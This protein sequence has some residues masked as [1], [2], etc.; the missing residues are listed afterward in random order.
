MALT[1]TEKHGVVKLLGLPGSVLTTTSPSYSSIVA[2]R[3]TNLDTD[4]E[5]SVRDYLT[6]IATLDLALDAARSR[7]AAKSIGDIVLNENEI[8]MLRAD[9]RRLIRELAGL[10]DLPYWGTP[11]TSVIV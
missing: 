2:G 5:A 7:A 4:T 11:G 6:R 8:P 1:A 9:R 3:L 10:L